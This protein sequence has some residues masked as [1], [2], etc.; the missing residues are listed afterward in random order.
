VKIS[1]CVIAKDEAD[2]IGPCLE[3][4]AFCDEIVVLDSGST[5][6]TV[7]ICRRAGARVLETDWPGW[8]AQKNRAV[9]AASHDWILALDADERVDPA[10]RAEIEALRARG[11]QAEDDVVAYEVT[12]KVRHLGR[13]I[14][15]GGWYPEWRVR[16]FDRRRARWGGEDPHDRVEV[17]GR[18]GRLAAGNLEHHT[19]RSLS[20]HV[21]QVNRFTTVS[22]ERLHAKGR[23]RSLVAMLTRPPARFLRMY[24]LRRGFL[25]GRAGFVVATV[26]A[27]YVFL[28]YAKLWERT[29]AAERGRG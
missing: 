28:K 5:D 9:A 26:G 6:D 23:R 22:A 11:E 24:V 10:L 2:R 29:R 15:H 19:Y 8:V 17:E 12:R 21:A 4:I 16:L 14:R 1:A 27:F 20:D 13:W 7:A 25:D 18:V 3:S